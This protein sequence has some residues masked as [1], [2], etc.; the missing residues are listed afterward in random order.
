LSAF[1]FFS[2]HY[3]GVFLDSCSDFLQIIKVG[4]LNALSWLRIE[5]H[6]L[7]RNLNLGRFKQRT[8]LLVELSQTLISPIKKFNLV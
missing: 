5:K 6:T 1:S 4:M 8:F 7:T 3:L 2:F